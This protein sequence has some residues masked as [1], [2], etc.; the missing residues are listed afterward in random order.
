MSEQSNMCK[1]A[2]AKQP[3]NHKSDTKSFLQRQIKLTKKRNCLMD[4]VELF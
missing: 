2:R 4:R 1:A 3:Y